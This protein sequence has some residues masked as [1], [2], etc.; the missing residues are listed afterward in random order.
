MNLIAESSRTPRFVP[1]SCGQ[2]AM[3]PDA[4]HGVVPAEED[5]RIE[6]VK[7]IMRV[8]LGMIFGVSLALGLAFFHDTNAPA[9]GQHQI[10]NW[11]VLRTVAPDQAAAVRRL[12]DKTIGKPR[13]A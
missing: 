8:F 2:C 11:D 6:S 3:E 4:R 13:Q 10:V 5:D 1:R 9:Y 12:W 7:I